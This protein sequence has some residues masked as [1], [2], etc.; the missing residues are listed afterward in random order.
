MRL[1]RARWGKGGATLRGGTGP[2]ARQSGLVAL[3][4]RRG[5]GF[6][7]TQFRS[8]HSRKALRAL[9]ASLWA[10]GF[11][12][13]A[14]A[15]ADRTYI[16]PNNGSWSV[17]GNW[18]PVGTPVATD[19]VLLSA[20]AITAVFDAAAG[21]ASVFDITVENGMTLLLPVGTGNLTALNNTYLGTT[22]G[23]GNFT[24]AGGSFGP[25][26]YVY[27]GH[28]GA[29]TFSQSGG[30]VTV[31]APGENEALILGNQATGTGTYNLS[32]G[33]LNV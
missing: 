9:A 19:N 2:G 33:T 30:T 15:H 28:T 20:G 5:R 18:S 22:G 31:S 1:R 4:A 32:G 10:V 23:A 21:N 17:A 29:G 12:G 25:G 16:G 14:P 24:V 8:I 11:Y 6:M 13:S 27:V 7:P 3:G 26:N